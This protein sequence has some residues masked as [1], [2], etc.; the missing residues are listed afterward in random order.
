V[1]SVAW[2]M[3]KVRAW[4]VN[5][6]GLAVVKAS[7]EGAAEAGDPV[8]EAVVEAVAGKGET[9]HLIAAGFFYRTNQN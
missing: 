6:V 8:A 5:A 2:A 9:G 7:E 3:G 4:Q 1:P